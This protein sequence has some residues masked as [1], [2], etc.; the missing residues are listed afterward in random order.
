MSEAKQLLEFAFFANGHSFESEYDAKLWL[1][2]RRSQF[3]SQMVR[4]LIQ[5]DSQI[6]AVRQQMY[7]YF[8]LSSTPRA[9]FKTFH[10]LRRK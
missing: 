9:L 2:D 3:V 10:Q 4:W 6:S 1:D 8:L 5:R 7:L